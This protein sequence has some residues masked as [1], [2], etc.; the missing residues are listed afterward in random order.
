MKNDALDELETCKADLAAVKAAMAKVEAAATAGTAGPSLQLALSQTPSSQSQQPLSAQP[1]IGKVR[2]N[3]STDLGGG[4]GKKR[5]RQG[6]ADGGGTVSAGKGPHRESAKKA[7]E[8]ASQICVYLTGF[9]GKAED[10]ASKAALQAV[11]VDQLG[12]GIDKVGNQDA[13]W[14]HVVLSKEE[15]GPGAANCRSA[16]RRTLKTIAALVSGK[17]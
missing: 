8:E 10:V 16:I 12:F 9:G 15:S 13:L 17:W 7:K 1:A 2:G 3:V 14:T 11:A 4:G 5:G 6:E